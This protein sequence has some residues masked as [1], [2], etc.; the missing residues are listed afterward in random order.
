MV[1]VQKRFIMKHL[2]DFLIKAFNAPSA[3]IAVIYIS[4]MTVLNKSFRRE[5]YYSDKHSIRNTIHEYA[6]KTMIFN[7][8]VW[9]I[10]VIWVM[11]KFILHSK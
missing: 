9:I 3:V 10:F 1:G 11:E 5:L 8:I 4:I 7:H 2:G 6:Q